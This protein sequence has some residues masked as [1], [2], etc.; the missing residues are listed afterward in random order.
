MKDTRRKVKYKDFVGLGMPGVNI[1]GDSIRIEF[2]FL[3]EVQKARF[4][5]IKDVKSDSDFQYVLDKAN[6]AKER[7]DR[8][9]RTNDFD[10]R[11]YI[12]LLPESAY[13]KKSKNRVTKT[14]GD[15]VDIW[16]RKQQDDIVKF[17]IEPNTTEGRY[18]IL[19][20]DNLGPFRGTGDRVLAF[21]GLRET[22]IGDISLQM[23]NSLQ[24]FLF[25]KKEITR[26][27]RKGELGLK[28]KTV[29]NV[30]EALNVVFKYAVALKEI[31]DNPMRNFEYL[32]VQTLTHEEMKVFTEDD[33][34][35]IE[36]VLNEKEKSELA[37]MFIFDCN[38]GLRIE[39]L[40][41]VAWEDV[42]WEDET[43]SIKRAFT[44]NVYKEPKE[45]ASYRD[46]VLP[47]RAMD[48]LYRAKER[49][50]N[51]DPFEVEVRLRSE[52]RYKTEKLR[53][54]FQNFSETRWHRR[55]VGK[56][57]NSSSISGAWENVKKWSG[58]KIALEQARH[59]F[60]STAIS[61]GGDLQS[62]SRQMGHSTVEMLV[63]K[64]GR[65]IKKLERESDVEAKKK[66]LGF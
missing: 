44:N 55:E 10:S 12:N 16:Y 6:F 48:M 22:P 26:G 20:G 27:A 41:A 42:N 23:L 58:V 8:G 66:R 3:H 51:S 21:R 37:E 54:I 9:L 36:E 29:N 60:A 65:F 45:T 46:I 5:S 61:N 49:T 30:F 13:A 24:T 38:T 47:G 2:L 17:R 57:W 31:E 7:I 28:P 32:S 34:N 59:T 35:H 25:N 43:I 40:L 11:E 62:I 14:F 33:I 4:C 63:Q 50:F 64:Y 56:P 15:V 52:S 1:H 39:E 18:R 53:F 19:T